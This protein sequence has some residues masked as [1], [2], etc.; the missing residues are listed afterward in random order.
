MKKTAKVILS[1]FLI[2]FSIY[3]VYL[4]CRL[5]YQPHFEKVENTTLNKDVLNQLQFLKRKIHAGAADE[6]QGIYPEGFLFLDALY[7]LSWCEVAN[8]VDHSSELYKEARTEIQY[9]FDEVNSAKGKSIFPPALPIPYGVFY[10]GWNNY[11]L[12]KKISVE[13]P[14]ERDSAEVALYIRQC[15][16]IVEG[17]RNSETPYPESYVNASWPSDATVAVASLSF[18][19]N[20]RT[21]LFG[22]DMQQWIAKVKLNLDTCGLLPHSTD[23]VTGKVMN[24]TRGN[25]QALILNFLFDIDPVFAREQFNL[26]KSKFLTTRFGLPGLR[27]YATKAWAEGDVDSGPVIFGIGGAASVVGLRTMIVFGEQETA[28]GLR[29]SI[30]AF[31]MAWTSDGEKKYLFGQIP[32]ADAFFVWGNSMEITEDKMLATTE[33][34]RGRFQL[35]SVLTLAVMLFLLLW[36]W[37]RLPWRRKGSS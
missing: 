21:P 4:N 27:E 22:T 13:D 3:I 34:W 31:G 5:Y 17:L 29:N 19:K 30:E 37:E 26:Y 15:T 12:G 28:I 32:M 2:V 10:T 11:L 36:M 7:G 20:I 6:M 9:A 18:E 35:Y 23:A 33:S 24:G 14:L 1:F 16:S 8:A 25:S